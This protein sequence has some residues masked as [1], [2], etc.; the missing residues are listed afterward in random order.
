M[1]YKDRHD[2]LKPF[3]KMHMS[4]C[5]GLNA[6]SPSTYYYVSDKY[7]QSGKEKLRRAVHYLGTI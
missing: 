2:K 5:F 4:D 6:A 3:K 1:R 7:N